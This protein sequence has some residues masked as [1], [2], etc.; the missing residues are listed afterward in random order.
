MRSRTYKTEAIIIKRLELGEADRIITAFGKHHGKIKAIAKGVR[1]LTSRKSASLELFTKSKLFLAKGKNLDI[2]TQAETIKAFEQI[3]NHLKAAKAA[4]HLAE[5]IDLLSVE[6]Q[7]YPEIFEF[8]EKTL[9][10][11][12]QKQH[13]TRGQIVEFERKVLSEMGFG[14]P[15]NE[16]QEDLRNFIESIIERRLNAVDIFK[17]V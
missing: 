13:A 5:L 6:N 12:N 3:R 4:Y 11:I 9:D 7:E 14:Y 17:D 2:I 10:S 15:Q 16:S 1:R 8:L